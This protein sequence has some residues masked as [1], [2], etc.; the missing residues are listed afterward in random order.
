MAR[1]LE[2][3]LNVVQLSCVE[4]TDAKISR[5]FRE[6]VL[7]LHKKTEKR[8]ANGLTYVLFTFVIFTSIF[9]FM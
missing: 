2:E 3:T 7:F 8:V 6:Y 1:Q 9:N 5:Q 4:I